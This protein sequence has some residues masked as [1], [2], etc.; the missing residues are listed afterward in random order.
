[1]QTV[2][3]FV[4]ARLLAWD[5]D[6][7]F[8]FPGDGINGLL[9]VFMQVDLHD[10][11]LRSKD[12]ATTGYEFSQTR[13]ALT[14]DTDRSSGGDIGIVSVV[15]V[16]MAHVAPVTLTTVEGTT[17]AKGDEFGYFQFGGSDTILLS[18]AGVSSRV[19]TSE[20]LR[21]VVSPAVRCNPRPT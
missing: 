13:G 15:S 12:S 3:D 8:A 17:V 19:D 10:H 5:V 6:K 21:H 9:R 18:Q 4:L 16:G 2:A 14:I 20:A 11:E 7:V 1:M